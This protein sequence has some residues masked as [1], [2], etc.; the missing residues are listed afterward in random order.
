MS[1][2]FPCA[3][4][5]YISCDVEVI[6]NKSGFGMINAGLVAADEVGR[7]LGKLSVNFKLPDGEEPDPDTLQWWSEP[8]RADALAA[9]S[10]DAK[11]PKEGMQ[12]IADFVH[13]LTEN[14]GGA[15]YVVFLFYPTSYDGTILRNYWL[16]YLGPTWGKGPFFA[17]IDIRS[18]AAGKLGCF[19]DA[20][21]K[22]RALAPYMPPPNPDVL[23]HTGLADAE[24]QL[25]LFLNLQR[26]L[27]GKTRRDLLAKALE[28]YREGESTVACLVD[29]INK[30]L[31]ASCLTAHAE[32]DSTGFYL[33]VTGGASWLQGTVR[34]DVR[35]PD[36]LFDKPVP[37]P[38]DKLVRE[39][40]EQVVM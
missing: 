20:A 21:K 15:P 38:I 27:T 4:S 13:D 25:Q 24:E 32:S 2:Y 9:N 18:Y 39:C 7:I 1:L 40:L 30:K 33:K 6:N 16:R 28:L 5:I 36:R 3:A 29:F 26:G 35:N 22:E 19:Y 23:K 12:E 17:C 31:T 14:Y 34:I 8:E 37:E 10:K 11:E